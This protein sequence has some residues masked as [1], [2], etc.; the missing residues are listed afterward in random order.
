MKHLYDVTGI[1][2]WDDGVP[3]LEADEKMYDCLQEYGAG[4]NL[5]VTVALESM[6]FEKIRHSSACWCKGDGEE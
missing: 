2:E 4:D 1:V 6:L 5:A 3:D